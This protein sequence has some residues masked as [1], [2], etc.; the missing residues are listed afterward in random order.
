MWLLSVRFEV[1]IE[2]CEREGTLVTAR[3]DPKV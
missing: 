1:R 3:P 2:A